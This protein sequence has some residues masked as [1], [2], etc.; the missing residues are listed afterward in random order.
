MPDPDDV[1]RRLEDADPAAR[2]PIA[3][4]DAPGPRALRERILMEQQSPT[5]SRGPRLAA[6]AATIAAIGVAAAVLVTRGGDAP[7][8]PGEPQSPGGM[9]SCAVMYDLTTLAGREQAFA[10]TVL[11]VNGDDV[12]FRVDEAFKG[13]DADRVEMKGASL[14]GGMT[15][16]SEGVALE[17]GARML[18]AGDGGFAWSCGF[19]QPYDAAVAADW[20]AALA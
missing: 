9:A 13:V 20:R 4:P 14:F 1:L 17:P 11:S 5:T 16:V 3:S 12:V 18:V 15:S 7:S 2:A 6:I 19:T 8:S 10:G